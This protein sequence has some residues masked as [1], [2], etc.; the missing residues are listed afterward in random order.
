M[1][2]LKIMLTF[3]KNN[4]KV[5]IFFNGPATVGNETP[6]FLDG[7]EKYGRLSFVAKGLPILKAF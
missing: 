7:T 2:H 6:L 1:L 4:P 5:P 3:L